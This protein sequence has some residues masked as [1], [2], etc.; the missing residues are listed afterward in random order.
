MYDEGQTLYILSI[1]T[2]TSEIY[3]FCLTVKGTEAQRSRRVLTR[4]SLARSW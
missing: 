2:T 4:N 1:I 3:S